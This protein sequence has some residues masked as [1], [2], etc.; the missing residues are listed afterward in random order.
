MTKFVDDFLSQELQDK[1]E[2]A[3][4]NIPWYFQ[5]QTVDLTSLDNYHYTPKVLETPY[6]VNMLGCHTHGTSADDIKPFVPIIYKLEEKMQRPFLQRIQRIK[7]NLY[8]R[9]ADYPEGCYHLPHVDMWDEEKKVPDPGEIFLY[10][11]NDADGE[12]HFFNEPFGAKDY[13]IL[14]SFLP[15]KGTGV[16]FD[17]SIVHTSTPPRISEYRMTLNFVFRK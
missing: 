9:R 2:I 13:T 3:L 4:F 14:K 8:T 10:Y 16:L 15:K 11:P 7:V 17:N 12:T 1:I 6:L 5:N